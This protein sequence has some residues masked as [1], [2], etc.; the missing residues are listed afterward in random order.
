MDKEKISNNKIFIAR[1]LNISATVISLIMTIVYITWFVASVDK[2]ISLLEKNDVIEQEQLDNYI[3]MID[4]TNSEQDK[5]N[6]QYRTST[7]TELINLDDKIEKIY[8]ILLN[9][10]KK[11]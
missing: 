9:M 11:I 5:T 1:L 8:M 3:N 6:D 10:K 2:R 4:Q 7:T